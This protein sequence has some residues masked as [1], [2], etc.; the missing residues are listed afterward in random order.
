MAVREG[1]EVEQH[2]LA[3]QRR[4]VGSR[5]LGRARGSP[6]G[7]IDDRHAA[8]GAVLPALEGAPVVPVAA[9]PGRHRQIGLEGA[10]LD[11]VEDLLPQVGQVRGAGLGVV[12]L[13]LE[14]GDHLGVVLGPEP[15]VVVGA[16]PAVV[17]GGRGPASGDRG[18]QISVVCGH[19]GHRIRRFAIHRH[20]WI[21]C[22]VRPF[23][24]EERRPSCGGACGTRRMSKYFGK[25]ACAGAPAQR[26]T[27]PTETDRKASGPGE[28]DRGVGRKS[29]LTRGATCGRRPRWWVWRRG[30]KFGSIGA[31]AAGQTEGLLMLIP[32][33]GPHLFFLGERV[34][35]PHGAA[36]R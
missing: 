16:G 25:R 12:V 18:R 30:R 33:R 6:A 13:G 19:V 5:G 10:R 21:S 15:F 1:V 23:P 36:S 17:G 9:D 7:G 3:R 24:V 34:A 29:S 32:S 4:L 28:K 11:L 14:V 2:L 31:T 8:A 20:R 27:L 22:G 35:V 26:R